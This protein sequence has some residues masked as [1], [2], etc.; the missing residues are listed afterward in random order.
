M[1]LLGIL[2]LVAEG[3]PKRLLSNMRTPIFWSSISFFLIYC[4]SLLYSENLEE[5]SRSI[6]AKIPLLVFPLMT[7]M[8]QFSEKLLYKLMRVFPVLLTLFFLVCLIG[9]FIESQAANDPSLLYSDNLGSAFGIQAV[10]AGLFINLA[11]VM[12]LFGILDKN[13]VSG[14]EKLL[15]LSLS[16]FLFG[17]HF[18]L[19]SRLAM[20]LG[21][22]IL[23]VYFLKMGL[24]KQNKKVAVII[25]LFMTTLP[26]LAYFSSQKIQNRFKS[27]FTTEFQ[28]D[29]PNPINHFNAEQKEGNWNSFTARLATWSCAWEVFKKAPILGQGVGDHF[30]QL[31]L[32]YQEKNYVL[33]LKEG[34]NTHNQ[35]LDALLATGIIGFIA[36]LFYFGYP[37]FIGFQHKE[38]L[39]IMLFLVLAL[40]AFTENILNRS[41]GIV[42]IAIL[43]IFLT[44]FSQNK[45][46]ST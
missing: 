21:M 38:W 25:L 42:I 14:K 30:D 3:M 31:M 16:L 33:G 46:H 32:E 12:M 39:W 8:L 44:N 6:T 40:S 43:P 36:L 17:I 1:G 5:G 26:F 34:Y 19:I 24:Q 7:S 11:L 23:A 2:A 9:Q 27:I 13:K 41:Q 28:Y 4:L 10:Y 18:L 29:N 37:I 22:L 20:L 15:F 35:Y 45:N